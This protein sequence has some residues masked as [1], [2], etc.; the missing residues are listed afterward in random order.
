MK[1]N[2]FFVSLFFT[3]NAY[4]EAITFYE[5]GTGVDYHLNEI[6]AREHALDM[7]KQDLEL[8][9]TKKCNEGVY[10]KRIS[11]FSIQVES[12][13]SHFGELEDFEAKASVGAEFK[14]V[15]ICGKGG[16]RDW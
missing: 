13:Y 2:I 16:C 10:A 7:A 3:I 8:K 5:T 4:C 11:R 6:T 9:A 15:L 1:K 14:C 12:N